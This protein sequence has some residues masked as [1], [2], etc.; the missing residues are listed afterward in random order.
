MMRDI[1]PAV[2]KVEFFKAVIYAK[3]KIGP[4]DVTM[5]NEFR[6]F[7]PGVYKFF[8]AVKRLD[9]K[10]LPLLKD[11]I[12]ETKGKYRVSNNS[13]KIL[14]SLLQKLESRVIQ[15][16]AE[17]MIAEGLK[18]LTIHDAFLVLPEQVDQAVDLINA[19]FNELGVNPPALHIKNL[20][21]N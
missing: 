20:A 21:E 17:R 4:A 13:H 10:D 2:A 1:D 9:E 8:V 15:L 3:R 14:P 6:R 12:V 18:P 19:T 11:I 7:F 5:R 16:V